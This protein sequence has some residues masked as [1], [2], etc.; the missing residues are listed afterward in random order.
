VLLLSLMG[1]IRLVWYTTLASCLLRFGPYADQLNFHR[2]LELIAIS[3]ELNAHLSTAL[4][5]SLSR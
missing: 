4:Q 1:S 2:Q 3:I 5:G